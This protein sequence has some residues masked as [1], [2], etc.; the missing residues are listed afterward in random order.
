MS[1]FHLLVTK[2]IECSP[3]MCVLL[4]P[5]LC[6]L[7]TSCSSWELVHDAM[8]TYILLFS[9]ML[10]CKTIG[11]YIIFSV[12]F[13]LS[14]QWDSISSYSFLPRLLS[15][16]QIFLWVFVGFEVVVGGCVACV[17]VWRVCV[18]HVFHSGC[19]MLA[20][21]EVRSFSISFCVIVL[22]H[23]LLLN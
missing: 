10:N 20:H 23:I 6:L 4:A 5:F 9:H 21:V 22:R 17:C 7:M 16:F 15:R 14:G 11:Q 12:S 2:T 8:E 1:V 3:T 13:V 19:T 18:L